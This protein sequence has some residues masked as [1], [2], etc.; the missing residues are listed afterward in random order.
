[1]TEQPVAS[2]IKVFLVLQAT[3][4]QH[5]KSDRLVMIGQ[6]ML[7]VYRSL[8]AVFQVLTVRQSVAVLL[9]QSPLPLV[10]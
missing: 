2:V 6:A 1:V 5:L 10:H 8:L 9:R 7:L 3:L 4:F